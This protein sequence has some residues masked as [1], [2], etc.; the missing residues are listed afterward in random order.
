[1]QAG[2]I[3]QLLLGEAGGDPQSL[4]VGSQY[5]FRRRNG[6]AILVRG[7]DSVAVESR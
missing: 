6:G 1:M 2:T 7:G 5:V 3:G 4:Q